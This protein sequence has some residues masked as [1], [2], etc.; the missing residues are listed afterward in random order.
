[1]F[2]ICLITKAIKDNTMITTNTIKHQTQHTRTDTRKKTKCNKE[3]HTNN[4]INTAGS[5]KYIREQK[6]QLG[7]VW[8]RLLFS[9]VDLFALEYIWHGMIT[10]RQLQT[11]FVYIKPLTTIDTIFPIY[12]IYICNV[13][14]YLIYY[15]YIYVY[16]GIQIFT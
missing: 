6:A 14:L 7:H 3:E 2:Y 11:L 5:N 16:I 1:M 9:I 15:I 10:S 12:S 8:Q 13:C 4:E